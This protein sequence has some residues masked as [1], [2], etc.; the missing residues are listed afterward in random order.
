MSN[1]LDTLSAGELQPYNPGVPGQ[2]L[3]PH[4][5]D[6]WARND[7]D[8]VRHA[9]SQG[10]TL[11]GAPTQATPQQ[12]EQM[13]AQLGGL[14]MH[15]FGT[16]GY[17]NAY[18]QATLSFM[19]DN[20]TKAPF[21]VV[22]NHNFELHGE[23]DYL[24]H[25]F[26]NM[27]QGL[28]GSPRAKQQYITACLQWLSKINKKLT[29]QAEG[30]ATA[31]GRAPNSEGPLS[32]LTEGQ[33]NLLVKHNE[34]VKINT[35]ESLKRKWGEASYTVNV[36]LAQNYLDRNP[37][38]SAHFDQWTGS[39]P[40]THMMNTESCMEFCFD[41]AIKASIPASKFDMA[42]E[43]F[44]IEALLRD[45]A[46]RKLYMADSVLQHRYRIMLQILG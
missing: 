26:A 37:Q 21:H 20:A 34:Q 14:F 27:V 41:A 22:P 5:H 1:E 42:Q 29:S 25:A 16:L 18:V 44:Q 43:V 17:P 33:M 28:S 40:W 12:A 38:A 31:Q 6:Q 30:S 3:A 7:V 19:M 45:P 32:Q 39:W 11:F 36:Q 15:D 46:G 35:S 23:N 9:P 13:L 4:N 10:Q 8:E 24:A 2:E